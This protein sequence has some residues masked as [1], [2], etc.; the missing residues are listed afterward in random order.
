M[1]HQEQAW[2]VTLCCYGLLCWVWC[3]RLENC[4]CFMAFLSFRYVKVWFCCG[5]HLHGN[6]LEKLQCTSGKRQFCM[7]CR[8]QELDDQLLSSK[9]HSPIKHAKRLLSRIIPHVISPTDC[10]W[11]ATGL[12]VYAFSRKSLP[13]LCTGICVGQ[14]EISRCMRVAITYRADIYL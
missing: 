3:C 8:N 2:W 12:L 14:N 10:R 5:D 4:T 13:L 11:I 9:L 1:I 7:P 6:T